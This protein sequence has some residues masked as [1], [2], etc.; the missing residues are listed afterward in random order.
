MITVLNPIDWRD[1][2]EQVANILHQC[3]FKVE[4]GKRMQSVRG[5][6]EID[7]YAEEIVQGRKYT[8]VCECK[9]WKADIPQTVV[10]AFRT[11]VADIGANV[12]FLITTSRFQSGAFA[13][14]G[15]TNIKLLDWP[16][17]QN[18]FEETW[19]SKHFV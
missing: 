12:G 3:R 14:S 19:Y 17:F 11:V 15:M 7:V 10:H 5:H 16:G 2:Q 13:A 8:V 6:V 4:V 18:E 9:N 1:L